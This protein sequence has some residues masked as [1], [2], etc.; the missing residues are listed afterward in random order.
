MPRPASF[1]H[2]S[3]PTRN[4]PYTVAG[5]ARISEENGGVLSTWQVVWSETPCGVDA[6]SRTIVVFV[7]GIGT[8]VVDPHCL[9]GISL[10]G[11]EE[12]ALSPESAA[13]EVERLPSQLPRRR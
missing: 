4:L 5:E 10:H 3:V 11:M 12:L 8:I 9:M 7:D 2:P 13:G 6:A 1:K